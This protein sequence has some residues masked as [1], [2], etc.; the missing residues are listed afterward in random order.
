MC[1]FVP[2]EMVGVATV[3]PL[4]ARTG[5]V[6]IF[7]VSLHFRQVLLPNQMFPPVEIKAGLEAHA[8]GQ[9]LIPQKF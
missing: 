7:A 2:P 4:F 1:A 3:S 9:L 8:G 6:S 5:T